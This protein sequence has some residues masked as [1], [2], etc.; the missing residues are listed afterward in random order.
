VHAGG[1]D[2]SP[3]AGLSGIIW[4]AA[5]KSLC[6]CRFQIPLLLLCLKAAFDPKK[7]CDQIAELLGLSRHVK[8]DLADQVSH[9]KKSLRLGPQTWSSTQKSPRTCRKPGDKIDI[10][11]LSI[12][13]Q[14][15]TVI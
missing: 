8:I 2:R 9:V 6:I 12:I 14:F 7:V 10:M 1:D 4:S 15:V 5:Q 13:L 3:L 11:N